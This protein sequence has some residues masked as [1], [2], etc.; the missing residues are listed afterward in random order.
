MRS[1]NQNQEGGQHHRFGGS[2]SPKYPLQSEMSKWY[3]SLSKKIQSHA[4]LEF[5][6]M[7]FFLMPFPSVAE[8]REYY[9]KEIK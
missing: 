2:A 7:H 4:K 5:K 3:K 1:L 9:L 6:E 8:F